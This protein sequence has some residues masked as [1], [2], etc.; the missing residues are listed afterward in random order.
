MEAARILPPSQKT[1]SAPPVPLASLPS[2]S[3]QHEPPQNE[4]QEV[5]MQITDMT[6]SNDY[7]NLPDTIPNGETLPKKPKGDNH[8]S[9]LN[10]VLQAYTNSAFESDD[11]EEE[12]SDEN[13]RIEAGQDAAPSS[14]HEDSSS[15]GIAR[16]NSNNQK[17]TR[18]ISSSSPPKRASNGG[19]APGPGTGLYIP[20][21]GDNVQ[22]GVTR[23]SDEILS[24]DSGYPDGLGSGGSQRDYTDI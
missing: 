11:Q 13:Q 10:Q 3:P 6:P 9:N 14:N 16:A 2:L 19:Q 20:G 18:R 21:V 4:E 1:S 8:V 22:E 23:F 5:V 17:S 12:K 24:N 15:N 7:S